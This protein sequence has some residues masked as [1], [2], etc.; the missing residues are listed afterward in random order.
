MRRN[1]LIAAAFVILSFGSDAQF[2]G[3]NWIFGDS[4]YMH[5]NSTNPPLIGSL[6]SDIGEAFASISDSTGNLLFYSGGRFG[7]NHYATYLYDQY[8]N[9][10]TSSS[11]MNGHAS[12][13]QGQIILP[14]PESAH[15]FYLFV[16]TWDS[17]VQRTKLDYNIID[18]SL[19]GGIGDVTL[20]NVLLCD[21]ILCEMMNAVKHANGR[22]WWLILHQGFSSNYL[23]Y[24]ITP[25]G[26]SGPYIQSIGMNI[27]DL[28]YG[29]SIFSE[30]GNRFIQA[31]QDGN[32][33][34]YDFDRCT[35]MLSNCRQL[36]DSLY[37]TYGGYYGCSFSP[38]GNRLYASY[39]KDSLF[40]FDIL[41]SDVKASRFLLYTFSSSSYGFGQHQLAEDGK[42]Y[43]T[44][45]TWLAPP[46]NDTINTTLSIIE[47][48][49]SL[50][51]SCNF[52]PFSLTMDGRYTIIGLPN[53]PNYALGPVA[54]SV[55]DSLTAA[56]DEKQS[57]NN[58]TI[59]P[60]PAD[61]FFTIR[62]AGVQKAKITVTDARGNR[63]MQEWMLNGRKTFTITDLP[64]GIYIV[65]I[66]TDATQEALKLVRMNKGE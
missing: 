50:G 28:I 15:L 18:M 46:L 47:D 49:D 26:I 51:T 39:W 2:R 54:G 14:V 60:N 20:K 23:L 61:A 10:M 56:V 9:Y 4:I 30:Q 59:Y 36:G 34:L 33:Q 38:D 1:Y 8:G 7:G 24:L 62:S 52:N 31:V 32:L 25:A 58:F 11:G 22:D 64:P 27:K 16:I 40:Q 37:S 29:E 57:K 48:P 45:L 42:I 12:A 19:N 3:N 66:Q 17:V 6:N 35:G 55:C 43:L 5:F 53:N 21:T 41:S 63:V 44:S 13:T 65:N